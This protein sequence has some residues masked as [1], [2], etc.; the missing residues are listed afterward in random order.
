MLLVIQHKTIRLQEATHAH[1]WLLTIY[2]RTSS[3]FL[4][5]EMA[6]KHL[7]KNAMTGIQFLAM[8]VLLTAT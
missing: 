2:Q 5:V 3:V 4:T 7:I 6:Y 1:V 8:D